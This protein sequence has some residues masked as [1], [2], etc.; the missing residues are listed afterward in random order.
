MLN[1]KRNVKPGKTGV[2]ACRVPFPDAP[3][4][5]E[6]RFLFFDASSQKWSYLSSDQYY[7]GE[8]IGWIGPLERTKHELGAVSNG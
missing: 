4:L 6:D 8:V 7:R 3:L 1:Y 5:H 2:Y